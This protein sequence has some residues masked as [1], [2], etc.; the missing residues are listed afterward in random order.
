MPLVRGEGGRVQ[1]LLS[2][3]VIPTELGQELARV[4]RACTVGIGTSSIRAI[5]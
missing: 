3:C 4:M 5:S 2:S 1:E